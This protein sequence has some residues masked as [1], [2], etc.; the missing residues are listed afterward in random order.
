M[1]DAAQTINNEHKTQEK[2][3]K[4]E[5]KQRREEADLLVCPEEGCTFMAQKDIRP[6]KPMLSAALSPAQCSMST[7]SGVFHS[8]VHQE[9][10]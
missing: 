2:E 5:N 4:D 8:P 3:A 6:C 7:L 10:H 1:E 9:P